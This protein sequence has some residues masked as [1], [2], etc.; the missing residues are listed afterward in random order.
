M[1]RTR[2]DVCKGY[3][4]SLVPSPVTTQYFFF[5]K[6]WST[7][8]LK[9]SHTIPKH[10]Y[11]LHLTGIVIVVNNLSKSILL[12]RLSC[13][14]YTKL[15]LKHKIKRQL[16]LKIIHEACQLNNLVLLLLLGGLLSTNGTV[17]KQLK[18]IPPHI[19]KFP[20]TFCDGCLWLPCYNP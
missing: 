1:S 3:E 18:S 7:L 5:K 17:C 16:F 4:P 15:F 10:I 12:F 19:D 20:S 13:C 14:K 9:H 8:L 11:L 2:T 6:V